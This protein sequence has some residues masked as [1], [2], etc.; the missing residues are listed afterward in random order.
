MV[1]KRTGHTTLIIGVLLG[2]FGVAATAVSLRMVAAA[3]VPASQPTETGTA[4]SAIWQ[5]ERIR[6]LAEA[7][8]LRRRVEA[9]SAD[10]LTVQEKAA[11]AEDRYQAARN[12]QAPLRKTL[13]RMQHER[14][15]AAARAA[16]SDL[17]IKALAEKM[18]GKETDLTRLI[19]ER[20]QLKGEALAIA[21]SVGVLQQALQDAVEES[22]LL[23]NDVET[24][25]AETEKRG[26]ALAA[27]GAQVAKLESERDALRQRI[28]EIEPST[29][30]PPP[31]VSGE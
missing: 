22:A 25:R 15:E 21:A 31:E 13:V 6:L 9:M 1:S 24:A 27:L 26:D 17:Q 14:D 30:S 2:L 18:A 29:P 19:A 20:D 8:A 3:R 16:Q 23:K 5:D 12:A 10:L 4:E 11:A 7:D 28:K